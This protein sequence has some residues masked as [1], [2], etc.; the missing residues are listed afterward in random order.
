[1]KVWIIS[2]WVHFLLGFVV[3]WVVLKRPKWATDLLERMRAKIR[4]WD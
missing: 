3:G 4:F 1:M 2:G